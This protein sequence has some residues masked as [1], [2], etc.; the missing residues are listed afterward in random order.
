MD[1]AVKIMDGSSVRSIHPFV[2][3]RYLG[4]FSLITVTNVKFRTW[5]CSESCQSLYSELQRRKT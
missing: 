1:K 3:H 5:T 4:S 2:N